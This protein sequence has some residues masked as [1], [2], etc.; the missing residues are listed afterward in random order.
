M[1]KTIKLDRIDIN[2]I[3]TLQRE[4]RITNQA[5]ADHVGLSPSPCLQRLRRLEEAGVISGYMAQI[6]LGRICPRVTVIGTVTL[7]DHDYEDFQAFEAIVNET[8]EI[9]ECSKVSGAFDYLLR[10]ECPTVEHYHEL[11]D[12]ML[13]RTKGLFRISSHVVLAHTKEFAGYP[14]DRLVSED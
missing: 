7:S 9:V 10:F 5:L 14:L 12:Q 1:A 4:G 8:P 11:S 13:A 2:I 3:K 6:A